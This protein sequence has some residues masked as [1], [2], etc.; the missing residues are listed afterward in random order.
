MIIQHSPNVTVDQRGCS[1]NN[2]LLDT[3]Y[4]FR[5]GQYS[6]TFNHIKTLMNLKTYL[7]ILRI[8]N[9]G[10]KCQQKEVEKK[11]NKERKIVA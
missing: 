1:K 9:D 2:E 4:V 3:L 7:M 11:K 8:C 6:K 5:L 10:A